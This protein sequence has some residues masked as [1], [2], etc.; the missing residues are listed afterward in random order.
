MMPLDVFIDRFIR[1]LCSELIKQTISAKI[2]GW[3]Y[4]LLLGSFQLEFESLSFFL[5]N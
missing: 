1:K 2:E 3:N 5:A 4:L